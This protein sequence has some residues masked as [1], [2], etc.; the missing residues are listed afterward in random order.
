MKRFT[1]ALLSLAMVFLLSACGSELDTGNASTT[2]KTTATGETTAKPSATTTGTATTAAATTTPATT[3]AATTAPATTKPASTQP[4]TAKPAATQA[5]TAAPSGITLVSL[6]S[7]VI[8]NETA[9]IAINGAPNTSYDINVV[10][11]SGPS[12]AAGL[13]N[14]TSDGSGNVSWSWKVGGQTAPGTYNIT[15]SGGGKTYKTT[16]IVQ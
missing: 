9:T 7:P 15:I 12:S 14:K 2:A 10:Y 13:D 6:T 5:P 4:I 8:Q 16:F 11:N 1:A 3:K